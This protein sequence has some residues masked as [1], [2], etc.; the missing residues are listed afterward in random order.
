VVNNGSF[1]ENFIER[2]ARVYKTVKPRTAVD[3]LVYTVEEFE[4]IKEKNLSLKRR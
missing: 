4:A 2:C 1:G 3:I